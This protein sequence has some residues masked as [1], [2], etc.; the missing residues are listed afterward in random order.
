M[1][2]TIKYLLE[3]SK[4]PKFWYNIN[5]DLPSPPPPPLHVNNSHPTPPSCLIE[6]PTLGANGVQWGP[7]G[8]KNR[9]N[10]DFHE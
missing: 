3:D 2:E 1:S 9:K 5:S 10:Q 4:A 8:S 7:M 6:F